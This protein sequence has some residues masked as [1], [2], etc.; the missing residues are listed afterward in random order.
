[1]KENLNN[2]YIIYPKFDWW[3]LDSHFT[4]DGMLIESGFEYNSGNNVEWL[5]VEDLKSE[6]EKLQI[7]RFMYNYYLLRSI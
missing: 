5:S 7:L 2:N 1:M 6:I 3:L 4:E